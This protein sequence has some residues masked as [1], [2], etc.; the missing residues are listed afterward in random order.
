M[1]LFPAFAVPILRRR[2]RLIHQ[3]I[4]MSP[5][6]N[7]IYYHYTSVQAC[8]RAAFKDIHKVERYDCGYV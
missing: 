3:E 1:L 6:N 8:H 4:Q 5:D 7:K 2:P